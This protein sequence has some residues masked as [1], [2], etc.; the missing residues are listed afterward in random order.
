MSP[1]AEESCGKATSRCARGV[2]RSVRADG[3]GEGRGE[4]CGREGS[5]AGAH[6]AVARRPR[7]SAVGKPMLARWPVEIGQK[8]HV[9]LCVRKAR[10]QLALVL[11]LRAARRRAPRLVALGGRDAFPA[12]MVMLR[13][14]ELACSAMLAG[15]E[16]ARVKW[17]AAMMGRR[18][19]SSRTA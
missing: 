9:I 6:E 1:S 10:R 7:G 2:L 13:Q 3:V 11:A 14:A 17:H 19:A 16:A 4:E 5:P 15:H 18:G 8:A 12:L